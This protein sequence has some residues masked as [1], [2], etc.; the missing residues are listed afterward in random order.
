[1]H[2]AWWHASCAHPMASDGNVMT[3]D[4][5]CCPILLCRALGVL[6][7]PSVGPQL[8]YKFAPELLAA[9][10]QE[11]VDFMVA[12][13]KRNQAHHLHFF[14]PWQTLAR[15]LSSLHV[16][17]AK[18]NANVGRRRSTLQ[19]ELASGLH[20]CVTHRCWC[21]SGGDVHVLAGV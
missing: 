3:Y 9:A 16:P 11:T 18:P 8:V 17:S 7:K 20:W 5:P 6:R 14:A 13:G 21:R 12:A 10:T 1:M 19:C 15:A 4:A 2:Y